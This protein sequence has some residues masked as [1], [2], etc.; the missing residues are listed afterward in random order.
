VTVPFLFEGFPFPFGFVEDF[1]GFG[2]LPGHGAKTQCPAFGLF[3]QARPIAG[4]PIGQA[5]GRMPGS[6]T[7]F[8]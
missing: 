4:G 5:L 2:E 1:R 7:T 6:L 8:G 3:R